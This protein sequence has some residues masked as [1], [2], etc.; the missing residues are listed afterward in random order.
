MIPPS[1]KEVGDPGHTD[2]HNAI[3]TALVDHQSRLLSVEGATEN[4]LVSDEPNDINLNN[5]TNTYH[6][7][8]E[9]PAGDRS[10]Q[11]NAFSFTR[12]GEMVSG[13][14]GNGYPRLR[15]NAAGDIPYV[16]TAHPTQSADL[17]QWRSASGTVMA[18]VDSQGGLHGGNV[19][20]TP[21]ANVV[22]SGLYQWDSTAGN[23]PQYRQQGDWVEVRGA[24]RRTDSAPIVF[25]GTSI[26]IGSLPPS[27]APPGGFRAIQPTQQTNASFLC[28]VI[29]SPDGSI[30]ISGDGAH[31][32]LW[33]SLDRIWFSRTAGT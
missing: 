11:P 15:S 26:L 33:V 20:P 18:R 17:H 5:T 27:V 7:K 30:R 32:P 13:F 3:T 28:Q 14:N 8:I 9:L 12:S 21:Y 31:S 6:Q 1:D 24:F 2:D 29:I 16:T 10:G 22:L 19:T 4:A 23:R 25:S